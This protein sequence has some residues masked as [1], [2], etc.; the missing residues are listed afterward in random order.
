MCPVIE[1]A[2]WRWWMD[3]IG[4]VIQEKATRLRELEAEAMKLRLELEGIRKTVN[5][6]LPAPDESRPVKRPVRL[7]S[8]AGKDRPI[9][10]GSNAWAALQV[11]GAAGRPLHID[12]LLPEV[13]KLVGKPVTKATL[14]G[15]ISEYVRRGKMFKRSGPS[16]FELVEMVGNG[17]GMKREAVV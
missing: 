6:V 16:M 10:E 13:E 15:Q 9:S 12:A 1:S 11:L 2:A 7:R 8:I 4:L 17:N 5:D 3:D 14:V